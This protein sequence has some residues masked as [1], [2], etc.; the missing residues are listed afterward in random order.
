MSHPSPQNAEGWG[1]QRWGSTRRCSGGCGGV[2][3]GLGD[4]SGFFFFAAGGFCF[5]VFAAAECVGVA[6]QLVWG[7]GLE[8]GNFL[9]V[10][11]FVDGDE[12]QVG[13]GYVEEGAGLGVL[14]PDLDADL[15]GGVEG[16]VDAGLEDEEVADVDGAYEVD[17]VHGGG[18]DVGAGVAIGGHGAG[19]IDEVHE[20]PAEEIAKGV[21][22]VGKDDLGH[23]GLG[24]GDSA[25]YGAGFGQAHEAPFIHRR[26]TK[27][28]L[29]YEWRL[30][31]RRKM[32]P[33]SAI[34][35]KFAN[36]FR[37]NT[38]RHEQHRQD[39]RIARDSCA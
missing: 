36:I 33:V 34:D 10:A 31:V 27:P 16:A 35:A 11:I 21:G 6:A 25:D 3:V 2:G 38:A 39:C 1:T 17:V 19:E 20:P 23:F 28:W 7:F 26:L 18:N 4:G 24:A 9:A 37:E 22:V 8:S 15:D 32:N 13:A 30:P 5:A 14:D 12:N 29:Q